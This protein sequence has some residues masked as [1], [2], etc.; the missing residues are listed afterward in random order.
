M[1][2]CSVADDFTHE[3]GDPAEG[4]IAAAL[5]FRASNNQ[6]C[7][8]PSGFSEPRLSKASFGPDAAGGLPVSKP[9]ARGQSH[10]QEMMQRLYLP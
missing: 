7:P 2:G 10:R 6:T 1:P 9:A 4:R 5:A 8:A 3:L